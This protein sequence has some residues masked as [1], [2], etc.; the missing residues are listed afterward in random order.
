M[1][2]DT[3][4][5]PSGQSRLGISKVWSMSGFKIG[6][7]NRE[8]KVSRLALGWSKQGMAFCMYKIWSGLKGGT[9]VNQRARQSGP[10][11]LGDD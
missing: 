11:R 7:G 8:R 3:T 6:K 10:Y 1:A 4:S 9:P 2:E 5:L